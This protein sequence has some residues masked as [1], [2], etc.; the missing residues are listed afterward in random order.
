MIILQDTREKQP[1]NFTSYEQCAAQKITYL[2]EGDYTLDGYPFLINIERKK[3]VTELAN[4]LGRKYKQFCAELEKLQQYKFRYILCEFSKEEMLI[5][6]T[7]AKLP[8]W[9][10]RKIR[11]SG[12]FLQH[13]VNELIEKYNIEFIFCGDRFSAQKKAIE[14]LSMAKE[15]YD[16]ERNR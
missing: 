2:S 11:M 16:K 10:Y 13:R 8:K 7:G 15:E 9:L 14:L 3:N 1:W 4:N 5:Y 6:P 12:K